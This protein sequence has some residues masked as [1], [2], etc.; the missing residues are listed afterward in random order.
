MRRWAVQ[1]QRGLGAPATSQP[2]RGE[3]GTGAQLPLSLLHMA[4]SLRSALCKWLP[5]PP[6]PPLCLNYWA[7]LP[8]LPSH[9]H[10]IKHPF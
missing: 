4:L 3:P 10:W 7:R 1:A 5:P 6:P 2:G 8:W 9:C